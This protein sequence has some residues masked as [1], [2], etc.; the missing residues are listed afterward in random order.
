M[1]S[2]DKV[3]HVGGL[4]VGEAEAFLPG[5]EVARLERRLG[6]GKRGERIGRIIQ[7]A[8][9]ADPGAVVDDAHA[10]KAV[11][12]A[13]RRE[14]PMAKDNAGQVD[15]RPPAVFENDTQPIGRSQ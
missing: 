12:V 8:V 13:Q 15:I 1:V 6:I 2:T 14:G 4:P 5:A 9:P 10:A 7:V 11:R 3:E